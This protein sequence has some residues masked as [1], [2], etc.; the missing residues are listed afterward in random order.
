M[1]PTPE[2]WW[3]TPAVVAAVIAGVVALVTLIVNGR[4][5]RADRQRQLFAAAFGDLSSYCEYPYIVRRRRHDEPEQERLRITTELSEVQ[6]KLNHN[7][8]V[9]RVEAPRVA[10]AYETLVTETR[11]IAG[12]SIHA[13]WDL[14]PI[15]TDSGVHVTDVD[16]TDIKPFEDAYLTAV[17]DHLALMPWWARTTVRWVGRQIACLWSGKEPAPAQVS[18]AADDAQPEAKAA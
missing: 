10:R 17:A 8:A 7:R 9:L 18:S 4:R 15:N 14:T 1:T 6:Q 2:P 12:A 13:G 5:A 16:L 11:R 3:V